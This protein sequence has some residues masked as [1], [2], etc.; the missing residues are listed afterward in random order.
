VGD[1]VPQFIEWVGDLS[2]GVDQLTQANY[3]IPA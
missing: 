1:A 3:A 2:C